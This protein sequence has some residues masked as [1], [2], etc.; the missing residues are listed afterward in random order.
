[1]DKVKVSLIGREDAKGDEYYFTTTRA[2]VL[3]D[4]SQS[5]VHV[6]PWE[7][8]GKFGADLVIRKYDPEHRSHSSSDDDQDDSPPRRIRRKRKEAEQ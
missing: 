8:E 6:F 4:L 7:E 1:M 5:V 2:P 3:V